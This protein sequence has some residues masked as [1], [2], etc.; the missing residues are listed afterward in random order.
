MPSLPFRILQPVFFAGL[1]DDPVLLVT[2]RP[3]GRSLMVDCG[4]IHHMAK[5]TVK[6][7]DTLLISHAHMDHF[8]GVD[9]FVRQVHVSPRTVELFGPPGIAARLTHKLAGYDWNLAEPFW[10]TIRVREIHPGLSR[11]YLLRGAKGF[12]C[13]PEGEMPLSGNEIFRTPLFTVAAAVCNHKIPVLCYRI[14]ERPAFTV[15]EE[16]LVA[17][18]WEKGPWL[19]TLKRRFKSGDLGREPLSVPRRQGEVP[20]EVE[21][22]DP[23]RLY[24][25]IRREQPPPSIG[26]VT[27]IAWSAENLSVLRS[28]LGGV[29]LL[30]CECAFLRRDRDRARAS[31]HL[32]TSDLNALV[33]EL[34]PRF[35]LPMHLSKSYLGRSALLYD[36]L[37]LPAGVTLLRLPE[38]RTP[39]PLLPREL[40]SPTEPRG[41]SP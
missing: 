41:E 2:V 1:L 37:E 19:Q 8:M 26:Y 23:A 38:Y 5:R 11:T 27:D 7:V 10:C 35:L 34:R 31:A 40:T 15:D 4:Q 28:L 33:D 18:G 32:C 16:R 17:A 39:R 3:S 29:T 12:A 21:V 30:V 14:D 36:E 13:R 22:A 25:A 6:S 24:R 20:G 9:A